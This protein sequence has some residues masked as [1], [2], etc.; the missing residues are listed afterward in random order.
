MNQEETKRPRRSLRR[1]ISLG[2]LAVV[3]AL[4]TVMSVM[5]A[6]VPGIWLPPGPAQPARPNWPAPHRDIPWWFYDI[7]GASDATDISVLWASKINAG[8]TAGDFEIGIISP[9]APVG[10]G[11]LV[12]HLVGPDDLRWWPAGTP[13]TAG[14]HT[15]PVWNFVLTYDWDPAANSG[16]G[17][18]IASMA[19][20]QGA[21][22]TKNASADVTTRV[23][24][25]VNGTGP[26]SEPHQQ[27]DIL[28]RLA[29]AGT[30]ATYTDSGV[31]LSNLTLSVDGGPAENLAINYP[32]PTNNA[33]VQASNNATYR[34]IGLVFLD[35]VIPGYTSD[36]TIT[37]SLTFNYTRATAGNPPNGANM[38]FEVKIGDLDLYGDMGDLP[39]NNQAGTG[40]GDYATLDASNG[41][42]HT[43]FPD[44]EVFL[45]ATVDTEPN[46]QPNATA[47]GDDIAAPVTPVVDDEDGVTL[48]E[49]FIPGT[50]A[51]VGV[52]ITD[53]DNSTCLNMYV[54]F[55][56][57]GDFADTGEH[58]VNEQTYTAG[59]HSIAV[60][61]PSTATGIMGVRVR[62]TDAC[63][64]GGAL[65][66]GR[67]QNG[68]VEDYILSALGNY[69]WNDTNSD[70]IQNDGA[71]SGQNGV[72]VNLLDGNGAPVLDGGSNPITTV[73][74]NDS[75][76]N[77][78]YYEFPGLPAGLYIVEFVLPNGKTFT[79]PNQGNDPAL[80]S[81]ADTT[82]GRTGFI[83]LA[84]GENNPT[85]DAGLLVPAVQLD[86]GDLPNT[87]GTTLGGNGA[88]HTIVSGLG[89]GAAI[90]AE[91]DGQPNATATG[92]DVNGTPD[93][94]DGV[95]FL[96]PLVAGTNADIR[97]TIT[98][99]AQNACVNLYVDFNGD[100]DFSDSGEHPINETLYSAG[101]QTATIAVPATATGAIGVR[102]RLTQA[103]GQGG[104]LPNG[105]ATNGEVEDYILG[106]IGDYVWNDTN[107]NGIQDEPSS[108]G[109]NGV[110]VNLLDADGDPVLDGD[111]N[112]ITTTTANDSNGNPG[113]YEFA[114]LPAGSYIVEFVAPNG[115]EFTQTGQGTA[116]TDS[117]A[118]PTT[119][120][121]GVVTL[122][123]GQINLT[124]DA[125]LIPE[126][127]ILLDFGDL[128]NSYGTTLGGNG[129]R[130]TIVSGL[131]L[132]AA[133]DA[134]ADGQPN[135]TATGDDVNG[136]PD[137]EDGVTFLS[138]LVAGTNAD[139]R[140]TINTPTQNACLN[141]YI[142]F[143]GDGDFGDSGEHV[144][145]EAVSTAGNK[146]ATI[147]VP[148]T[149]TGAMAVRARLTQACGEGGALPNGA[150]TSGEV[151][152]YIFGAIG[153]YVWNDTNEDG[154]QNEPA[155]A[156]ENGVTVNLLD[157][158]GAPVLDGNGDPI[159]TETANDSN[160][161]PGYYEFAGL[162]AGSYIVEFVA[163]TGKEF[164]QTGQGTASTDSNAD[165]TTGQSGVVTLTAG[166]IN[167]TIDAGLIPEP[168]IL[169]DFGDLPNSYG[170]LLANNG[171][172]HTI[173]SGLG[174]GAAIDAEA[175]GQ[176]NASATGD[177]INGTP[178]DEDGVTFLTPLVGGT[179]AK[180]R[181]TITTPT[182][183]ACL[184]L[185]IDFN[186]DG[187]FADSGEHPINET[188]YSAGNQ[189]VTIAVPAT[190][191]EKFGVRARL[192]QA[193]G[194]G[195][196]TSGGAA[197]TGEVEDYILGAI[198]NYVWNDTNENGIQDEPSSAGEDG[199][200][201]RL[202]DGSGNPV[203]D[204][205]GNA[206]TT[207]TTTVAGIPGYYEFAGLPAGS[208]IVEFVAPT[209]KTF[210][211]TGQGTTS[212][213]SNAD[214]ATGR[215]GVI[216][217]TAGQI[218]PTIDAGLIPVPMVLDFGDLPDTY[219]TVSASDGARHTIVTGVK[220]G[221][222][223]D[224]EANGQPTATATGDD[225]N[226]TPDDEDG[227]TFVTPLVAGKSARLE[228]VIADPDGE[229]CLSLFVDYNGDGSFGSGETV[230]PSQVYT[231][232]T[233]VVTFNVPATATGIMG[234]RAR[235]TDECGQG[236]ATATGAAS[237]GEVEDYILSTIGDYVWFDRNEN[238]IQD[239]GPSDG[240]NGVTVRLLDSGGNP[241]LDGNGN[242]IATV[243]AND[244]NGNPGYYEFAGL[245]AGSYIVQF[246]A[247][248]GLSFTQTGQGTASTDSNADPT[249]GRTAVV[250]LTS[251]QGNPTID[252]GLILSPQSGSICP[253]PG[254]E[255]TTI[256]AR[257]MGNNF[258][259]TKTAKIVV[260][261]NSN[262]VGLYAQYAGKDNGA[263]PVRVRFA[264][265]E[266]RI[267]DFRGAPPSPAYRQFA[268][269]LYPVELQPA[270]WVSVRVWDAAR[271][272]LKTPRA[273]FVYAT[274]TVPED[275]FNVVQYNEESS[276]NEVYWGITSGPQNWIP[277]QTMTVPI[278][279][280]LATT[281]VNVQVAL[282]E[283]DDDERPIVLTV[284][285]GTATWQTVMYKEN[286]R[287]MAS[288]VKLTL[289]DVPAG[290]DEVTITLH[291]PG[292][293]DPTYGTGP[294][295]GDSVAFIGAAANYQCRP[296]N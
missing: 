142:D 239:E 85:I 259:G 190:V 251:G 63:A 176:P 58:P 280:P 186:A 138:P 70:G 177:D 263:T 205:D 270:R 66:T 269:Y 102:A 185:Y 260:P 9:P 135:A 158:D 246:V 56:G 167:L 180:I 236:G 37:G 194:Q 195:G 21:N 99:P 248:G 76:G 227:V 171:P 283:N 45:G 80:D 244:S 181:F 2:L 98:T 187:D 200:T 284:T 93:D 47:T 286:I 265:S 215:T 294:T 90:D 208:Y 91:A 69:V 51:D 289:E 192:T 237:T 253:T 191:T 282:T 61:V 211:Q 114:G 214:P 42:V 8:G 153:D 295:G 179:N 262:L 6:P 281:D 277:T 225:I 240:R 62:I 193:C 126:P 5:A 140:F 150:A 117:N 19:F 196:D 273:L 165:P 154:I 129:A 97:F 173:V 285:A 163:P 48:G 213:D 31:S 274:H 103:C 81:N 55:N 264:T 198:G 247:P 272:R 59:S 271:T 188:L 275:Y 235:L 109:Q 228:M 106:A 75:N 133:I 11:G 54:D 278:D 233:Q 266:Q 256:L 199:V 152:D 226:G 128:P 113:Y 219:K 32:T 16:N 130:H 261:N 155:S 77:P 255:L 288:V 105:A 279:P 134:E 10:N 209:G 13:N 40:P 7:N 118:D 182:Q 50:T 207:T 148:A 34:Q 161:N 96:T 232:G 131:G 73:T 168:V 124:I 258:K 159:S 166:Q 116:S 291:S 87:Y 221:A 88:R 296:N 84:A 119:G 44:Y 293:F 230:V 28:L 15:T 20:T 174:L 178:D 157:G 107:E 257:G 57:D 29:A 250:T 149:A 25:F 121:S 222:A 204:G 17:A 64:Q 147:L 223:I 125:G 267:P 46:G 276:K 27:T 111:G 241:V 160:G 67:A 83:D 206:I 94:E 202:L 137:D 110:T 234:V 74:A 203:L 172:R 290:T 145:N 292:A 4:V 14:T 229:A 115:K 68:E 127:V 120:R 162:P 49:P 86:F 1:V 23:L 123:A 189:T 89:L 252:A 238:G 139:I 169:L 141:L 175:D 243:T 156:G 151:E 217:L 136:T 132:G 30:G 72:T 143:N 53:P 231:T 22:P 100:G 26:Y 65:P 210:T 92:D 52:F 36:F 183:N 242:D 82:T 287:D 108:A 146:T 144:L 38:M 164:T 104:A 216:T 212:N 79:Q 12:P 218:D 41:P 122:T 35:N 170:T 254:N 39:D 24:D 201:V 249:T 268:V 3:F 78:G 112:A 60:T 95:T 43:I 245:P 101:N 18:A 220:L 71:A 184:N 197:G 224:S 33:S